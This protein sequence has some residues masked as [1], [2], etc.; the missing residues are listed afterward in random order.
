MRGIIFRRFIRIIFSGFL[1]LIFIRI[2][3]GQDSLI[4]YPFKTLPEAFNAIGFNPGIK[5]N[6]FFVVTADVHYG[7]PEGDGMMSVIED[8][9]QMHFKPAFFV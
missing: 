4:T 2:S 6:S 5:G 3:F 8:I 7:N 1:F 9:N